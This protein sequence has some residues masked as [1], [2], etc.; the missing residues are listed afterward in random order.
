MTWGTTHVGISILLLRTFSTK[1]F[2]ERFE[3][4]KILFL[5]ASFG[6][7]FPDIDLLI[8]GH[9]TWSH[10]VFF[11]LIFISILL[12]LPDE[13]IDQK[14]NNWPER[15]FYL[16]LFGILWITHLMYDASFGAIALF[17]PLDKR[18]YD[19]TGGIIMVLDST[20]VGLGGIFI[21]IRPIDPNIGKNIFFVNWTAEERIAYFGSTRIK[22]RVIDFMVHGT[23]F[24]YWLITVGF[25][26]IR[27]FLKKYERIQNT[28]PKVAIPQ[29]HPTIVR[30]FSGKTKYQALV[31][32][33]ISTFAF[34][35]GPAYGTEW[36]YTD[37]GEVSFVVL[38][39]T[40]RLFGSLDFSFPENTKA[41]FLV[42]FLKSTINYTIVWGIMNSSTKMAI[43]NFTSTFI[44]EW[45]DGNLTYTQ[46]IAAYR[47]ELNS[48][49]GTEWEMS[50]INEG[51]AYTFTIDPVE[52]EQIRTISIGF[53]LFD[54]NL[55]QFFIRT[56]SVTVEYTISRITEY[57]NG[58]IVFWSALFV[59]LVLIFNKWKGTFTEN[60]NNR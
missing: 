59:M 8:G 52:G 19:I 38:S 32:I 35:S 50:A 39:D 26:A 60:P 40:L 17:Y 20:R 55:S 45:T 14:I 2:R 42:D 56:S 15:S 24:L 48:S 36:S 49:V 53:G 1:S 27:A 23:I 58:W 12:F 11:P 31:L 4:N 13:L 34:I 47:S 46:M 43:E 22:F 30:T 44:E 7:E 6:A 16:K 41:R 18:L 9:R 57:R 5:L 37:Q 33:S 28:I 3:S 25:P 29:F 51:V 10:S 21:D 54:W